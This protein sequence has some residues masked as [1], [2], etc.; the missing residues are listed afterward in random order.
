MRATNN[1]TNVTTTI[2]TEILAVL[3]ILATLGSPGLAASPLNPARSQPAV[4]SWRLYVLDCGTI[5]VADTARYGLKRGEV[6]TNNLSVPCFLVA[7]SKGLLMRDVGAV[8]Y[9]EWRPTGTKLTHKLALPDGQT[10]DIDLTRSLS[11]QLKEIGYVPGDIGQLASLHYHY[12][13]TANASVFSH[14]TWLVRKVGRDAMFSVPAPGTTRRE[15][16]AQLKDARTA[17]V[18][19]DDFDVIGDGT[20]V[21]KSAPS[22]TPGH[23]ILY[24]RLA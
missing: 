11:E 6:A 8:P 7:H 4:P 21:T 13:H 12:D 3:V 10:R 17:I 9:S 14:S 22:H 2:K 16:Y 5:H 18:D 1:G 19:V 15:T 23:Q 24:L 20:A